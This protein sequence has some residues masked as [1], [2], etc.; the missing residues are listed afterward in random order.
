MLRIQFRYLN[1]LT[2]GETPTG[3]DQASF[4]RST[5]LNVIEPQW[6]ENSSTSGKAPEK[7][8]FSYSIK[9]DPNAIKV[10]TTSKLGDWYGPMKNI[11]YPIQMIDAL[12]DV[13]L[14]L[15]WQ[16]SADQLAL[17]IIEK[18]VDLR[19]L[20]IWTLNKALSDDSLYALVLKE[21]K[22]NSLAWASRTAKIHA[23][24]NAKHSVI[25][26]Q[27]MLVDSL[28]MDDNDDYRKLINGDKPKNKIGLNEQYGFKKEPWDG[29]IW[30]FGKAIKILLVRRV[31]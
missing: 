21:N 12:R 4:W 1:K 25:I 10:L 27:Q 14:N 15:A 29:F 11:D 19:G 6:K 31:S 24:S 18:P 28:P 8:S 20:L 30:P 23:I 22:I 3:T 16:W 17:T 9:D 2:A 26:S 7:N 5:P 13:V